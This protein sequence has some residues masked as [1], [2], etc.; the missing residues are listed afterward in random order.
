MLLERAVQHAVGRFAGKRFTKIM[1]AAVDEIPLDSLA[2]RL[3]VT[4]VAKKLEKSE[5]ES[6][7]E[8][9]FVHLDGCRMSLFVPRDA[10]RKGL[11][12]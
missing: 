11:A 10:S 5:L 3:G 1:T 12:C 6:L 4:T 2:H 8:E 7:S 9:I